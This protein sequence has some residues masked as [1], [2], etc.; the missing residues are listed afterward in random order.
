MRA[1]GSVLES[2]KREYVLPTHGFLANAITALFVGTI[3]VM[4]ESK[5]TRRRLNSSSLAYEKNIEVVG[6]MVRRSKSVGRW[7]EGRAK[8][9]GTAERTDWSTA[10]A[11]YMPRLMG[12][13]RARNVVR[14]FIAAY[15]AADVL[16]ARR[17]NG[18]D[19]LF[20]TC[21]Y[22]IST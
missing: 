21:I 8:S 9:I 7:V 17:S 6:S 5:S 2:S 15:C 16:R 19:D 18:E 3:T 12:R 11:G 1:S 10:T 4:F 14:C 20:G 13:R 22:E